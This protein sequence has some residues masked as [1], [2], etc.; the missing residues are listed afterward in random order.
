MFVSQEYLSWSDVDH[1]LPRRQVQAGASPPNNPWCRFLRCLTSYL[2]QAAIKK[3]LAEV[4]VAASN[5]GSS[6]F[7]RFTGTGQVVEENGTYWLPY[8]VRLIA[9]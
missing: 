9:R 1:L 2:Q 5:S 3:S 6:D 4:A 7:A 8:A